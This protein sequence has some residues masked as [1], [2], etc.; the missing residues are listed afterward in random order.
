MPNDDEMV[1]N[2]MD[3]LVMRRPAE[4]AALYRQRDEK[5][6]QFNLMAVK[7]LQIKC[8]RPDNVQYP[9]IYNH[10]CIKQSKLCMCSS[11]ECTQHREQYDL[12]VNR[13]IKDYLKPDNDP[14]WLQP[15]NA[16]SLLQ[17]NMPI[18]D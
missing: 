4:L 1:V 15:D 18:D 7:S 17:P 11:P 3:P 14:C 13:A 8:T 12:F 5:I 2:D 10:R 9:L 6:R 16:S